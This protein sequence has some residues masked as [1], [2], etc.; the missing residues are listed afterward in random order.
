MASGMLNA[1]IRLALPRDF[2]YFYIMRALKIF[3]YIA[4]GGLLLSF[5][6]G[7][8]VYFYLTRNLPTLNVL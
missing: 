5:L 8:G 3:L 2:C 4:G 1:D 6:I 7:G